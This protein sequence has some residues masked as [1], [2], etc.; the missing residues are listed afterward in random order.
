MA[1]I[2]DTLWVLV[3]GQLVE[4]KCKCCGHAKM[5][6]KFR[7]KSGRVA[8]IV[9]DINGSKYTLVGVEDVFERSDLEVYHDNVTAQ[10]V[11]D[12]L[13]GEKK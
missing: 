3:G 6:E 10:H 7:V 12:K 2:D 13:N 9:I 4:E 8:K 11:C 1:N 5:V